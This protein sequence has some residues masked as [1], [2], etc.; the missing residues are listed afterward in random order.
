MVRTRL[1]YHPL[2]LKGENFMNS[3]QLVVSVRRSADYNS[4]EL[5]SFIERWA[6]SNNGRIRV[7][8]DDCRHDDFNKFN[9][10]VNLPEILFLKVDYDNYPTTGNYLI[11]I[12]QFVKSAV[13]LFSG[14]ECIGINAA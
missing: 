6:T 12:K 9:H 14:I 5:C 1:S 11:E 4:L 13:S 10:E 2:F 8:I 3:V 7:S